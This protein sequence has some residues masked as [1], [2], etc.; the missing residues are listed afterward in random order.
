MRFVHLSD[1]HIKKEGLKDLNQ[2][3]KALSNDLSAFDSSKKI[4]FILFTGDLID[5]GGR[6]FESVSQAFSEFEENVIVPLI[7]CLNMEKSRFVFIP[8]NHDIDRYAD[9]KID[10]SGLHT[11]LSAEA[12]V[13]L[14]IDKNGTKGIKRIL[15]FK[16]FEKDF[17]E[18]TNCK[19]TNFH[20][21]YIFDVNNT[22]IGISAF[23]TAWRCYD[24][25]KD[26]GNILLGKRQITESRDFI[27]NCDIKIALMHHQFDFLNP[28]DMDAVKPSIEREYDMVFCGHVHKGSNYSHSSTFGDMFMSIAPSNT[29]DN[30]WN[31]DQRYL[32]GYAIVDYSDNNGV[33]TV[34]NRKYSLDHEMYLSNVELAPNEGVKSYTIKKKEKQNKRGESDYSD[35]EHDLMNP[36]LNQNN[37][38]SEVSS[39][40]YP[41]IP[42]NLEISNSKALKFSKST[43]FKK[44]I[45][46][47]LEKSDKYSDYKEN[48]QLCLLIMDKMLKNS[49]VSSIEDFIEN[50]DKVF[51]S[52]ENNM[53]LIENLQICFDNIK[54][55]LLEIHNLKGHQQLTT[56]DDIF[57]FIFSDLDKHSDDDIVEVLLSESKET[58]SCIEHNRGMRLE[59]KGKQGLVM[60]IILLFTLPVLV[61][62]DLFK[63]IGASSDINL[64]QS[65]EIIQILKLTYEE[66][67]SYKEHLKGREDEVNSIISSIDDKK[68]T[69]VKG[70]KGVGKSAIVSSV[71]ETMKSKENI[72]FLVFSFKY[73]NNIVEF[74]YSIIE[75]CNLTIV[76]N[77]DMEI[78]VEE[79]KKYN[80]ENGMAEFPEYVIL[81]PYFKEAIKR[82]LKENVKVCII[83][84]SLELVT[85]LENQLKFLLEDIIDICS[86]MLVTGSNNECVSG[87][88]NESRP[89]IIE[90][91]SFGRNVIPLFTNLKDSIPK[92]KALNDRVYQRTKGKIIE[93]NK[94][95]GSGDPITEESIENLNNVLT[96]I[97]HEYI[98]IEEASLGSSILEESLLLFSVF[99]DIEPLSLDNVQSFL[100]F[101]G[102]SARMPMIRHE[103]RKI[104][105]HLS[106]M[107]FGRIRFVKQGLSDYLLTSYF[108]FRDVEQFIKYIFEWI[109]NEQKLEVRFI[110]EFLRKME[111]KQVIKVE[112]F[113]NLT[114]CFMNNLLSKQNSHKLFLLGKYIFNESYKN[115]NLSMK[116][117]SKAVESDNIE[118]M[119]FLGLSYIEGNKVPRNVKKAEEMLRRAS[120][121]KDVTAMAMLGILLVEE[122][123]NIEKINE[124][125]ELLEEASRLGNKLG[126]VQLAIR[127]L[128]GNKFVQD[129]ERADSL[130][131]ELVEGNYVAA[132][133]VMGTR[134]IYGHWIER[135][136]DRGRNLL[137]KAISN[138]SVQAKLILAR[139][140]VNAGKT[141]KDLT[142]GINL[143]KELI[144]NGNTDAKAYYSKILLEG[145]IS[146]RDVKNG[147]VLLKE[148]V[149]EG[150]EECQLDYAIHLF[151]GEYTVQNI[152]EGKEVLAKLVQQ[153]YKNAKT[154]YG[155]MLIDG[156][157]Y[158]K[159]IQMGLNLINENANNGDDYAKK[160]LAYRYANGF[161]LIKDID[162][163]MNI[164]EELTKLGDTYSEYFLAKLLLDSENNV[165]ETDVVRAVRLL[166][167]AE[168]SGSIKAKILLGEIYLDGEHVDKNIKKG[169]GYLNDAI[170]LNDSEA[171]RE[172]GYR[173]LNGIGLPI[174]KEQARKWLEKS[175]FLGNKLAKTI[176]GHGII[177]NKLNLDINYGLKLLEEV[178]NEEVNA[179]RI[180]GTM[181]IS[182]NLVSQDKK[183]G[184]TLLKSAFQKGDKKAGV[185]LANMMLD[186][187][188]LNKNLN[189]GKRVLDELVEGNYKE[190]IIEQSKRLITGNGLD[191]NITQGL[192]QL[193]DL[194]DKGS[195]KAMFN[196]A[197]TILIG[198]E[199]VPKDL[200]KGE[201]LLREAE[202]RNNEDAR[203]L[204]AR[205][206]NEN[207]LKVSN[208]TEGISFLEKAVKENDSEAMQILANYY[209]EGHKVSHNLEY[210]IE[211]YE[212]SIEDKDNKCMVEYGLKLI[213]GQSIEK[214]VQRGISLLKET[215]DRGYLLGQYHLAKIY[216]SVE[217]VTNKYEEGLR[218][219]R[220]LEHDGDTN[221]KIFLAR[222]L[223]LGDKI[224]MDREEATLLFEELVKE[225]EDQGILE[226][227]QFLLDG[228]YLKGGGRKGDKLIRQLIQKG[229]QEAGHVYASRLINGD[230]VQKHVSDGVNRI[231]K[232]AESGVKEAMLEYG[233][234]LKKGIKVGKNITKGNKFIKQV[235]GT[236]NSDEY[237][238]FGML[239]YKLEDY[240]LATELFVIAFNRGNEHSGTSLAY[241]L[242]RNEIRGIIPNNNIYLLLQNA[243]EING[244]TAVI[245]LALTIVAENDLEDANW[246]YADML[247]KSLFKCS[248]AASWWY[249]SA[250]KENDYEGH[251]IIGWLS[252]YN[253]ILD[254]D[255][256][257]YKDRLNIASAKWSLPDW[258][259]NGDLQ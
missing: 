86:I 175:V 44:Y 56:S 193:N 110:G 253:I 76:N 231:K 121:F 16:Q 240:E 102:I 50:I 185:K 107:R 214:D 26:H 134:Y 61:N 77:I 195:L 208:K 147:L 38:L 148:L 216:L 47:I 126:K 33:I 80:K 54:I 34:T 99:E 79:V 205:L 233:I 201:K 182:G 186:G 227:S 254:P 257:S 159:N 129:I 160:K 215:A 3:V 96:L 183:K 19:I 55:W 22:K 130:L 218:M 211:L 258:L 95:T 6:S 32:N 188:Y 73:S 139:Y 202:E 212:R 228:F 63:Q 28:F 128:M 243:L 114:N 25:K 170:A 144:E 164:F 52:I 247:I 2:I 132:I 14:F 115:I 48:A 68:F 133:R 98:F 9:D 234:R 229:N 117:L 158:A 106:N 217:M 10:E 235:L 120:D 75:Q 239:A 149:N 93:L 57:E 252:K 199:D 119:V 141:E 230:G 236:I 138:G 66:Y 210:A 171:M 85:H 41:Y 72:S 125:R 165:N 40:K 53:E 5:Q 7:E 181:Y 11:T 8:G 167:K 67:S 224:E 70:I 123:N 17:H 89:N 153:N 51:S 143:L 12:E 187:V 209:L 116:F 213:K 246:I 145:P 35:S 74:I 122:N 207:V 103:L 118:S 194:S 36:K 166:E 245:N 140:Q 18:N 223:S 178:S 206:I 49:T 152:D 1:F 62:I 203:R 169:L 177:L 13:S 200:R 136:A 248:S 251:L 137:N 189:E 259:I 43:Y 204:L 219:M 83:I 172:L 226:Y 151:S 161:G 250:K 222:S 184:E 42:I 179:M 82:S 92:E 90:I 88:I 146:I 37:Y 101:R 111:D 24:S 84:D 155:E 20:S 221:A 157:H 108:S 131:N 29:S 173:Y 150:V 232:L 225:E 244:D 192:K 256:F 46:E 21:S 255:N 112:T 142:E 237:H 58:I 81:Q 94:I 163:A 59:L 71:M 156:D 39:E 180:L 45:G 249:E 176:L 91:E 127:L 87:F 27:E 135:D 4:D 174:N 241:M 64:I 191:K 65:E 69:I 78:L 100:D 113:D 190:A 30:I 60:E 162:R 168:K 242:R 238:A 198:P 31:N 220:Q 15:P 23:N 109:S 124:S 104:E 197:Q 154:I 105:S 196:L 97:D